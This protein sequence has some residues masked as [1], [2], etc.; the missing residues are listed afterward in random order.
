[1]NDA[2]DLPVFSDTASP[3]NDAEALVGMLSIL[4]IRL[5]LPEIP[6]LTPQDLMEFRA[7]SAA[8]L[9]SFRGSMLGYAKDLNSGLMQQRDAGNIQK[10]AEFFVRTE[11]A[12]ASTNFGW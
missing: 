12:P 6:V 4:S 11:I 3:I 8:E 1:M 5:L 2:P 10:H 9:R 7:E